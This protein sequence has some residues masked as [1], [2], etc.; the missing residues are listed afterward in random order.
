MIKLPV[1]TEG[2][3]HD[4]SYLVVEADGRLLCWGLTKDQRDELIQR[5]NASTPPDE[6]PLASPKATT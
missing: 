5:L 1:R 3:A 6:S 4:G 2:K